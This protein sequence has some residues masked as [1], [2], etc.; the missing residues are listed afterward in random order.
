MPDI[1][2]GEKEGMDDVRIRRKSQALFADRKDSPIV[3]GGQP[4]IF[5]PRQKYFFDQSLHHRPA[6]ATFD[7]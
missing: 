7:F 4:G 6:A 5:K 1:A 2:A 3:L